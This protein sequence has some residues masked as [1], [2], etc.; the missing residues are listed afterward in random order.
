MSISTQPLTTVSSPLNSA[1]CTANHIM[2][3]DGSPASEFCI[4]HSRTPEKVKNGTY[5][6][7]VYNNRFPETRAAA[8]LAMKT[9]GCMLIGL[10]NKDTVDFI[11]KDLRIVV[12]DDMW[13]VATGKHK[14]AGATV[15]VRPTD[16]KPFEFLTTI[17]PEYSTPRTRIPTN[18]ELDI[19]SMFDDRAMGRADVLDSFF[20]G[21]QQF[22]MKTLFTKTVRQI[23]DVGKVLRTHTDNLVGNR[24]K[25]HSTYINDSLALC[26][27]T[28]HI[29]LTHVA[30]K[31]L[32][33]S[34]LITLT[35]YCTITEV[36]SADDVDYCSVE[37]EYT[38]SLRGYNEVAVLPYAKKYGGGGVNTAA[39]IGK[40]TYHDFSTLL[41][42]LAMV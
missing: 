2:Y 30:L 38:V 19:I 33:P 35:Y 34:A 36:L 11:N 39:G 3:E 6:A 12:L 9:W 29:N 27:A 23:R 21:A 10:N 26:Q 17:M 5:A 24:V 41:K 15:V 14:D 7:V 1:V 32:H 37:M 13:P 8:Y 22:D 40:I 25:N 18:D 4:V 16:V 28:E 42:E 31:K 20:L